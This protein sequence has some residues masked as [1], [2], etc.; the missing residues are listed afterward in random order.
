[1][2]LFILFDPKIDCKSGGTIRLRQLPFLFYRWSNF[3]AAITAIV[4][5]QMP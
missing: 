2:I 1:M 4:C 5:L 3:H